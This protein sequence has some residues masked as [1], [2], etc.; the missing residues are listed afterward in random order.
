MVTAGNGR[1]RA[2][3][4]R[5]DIRRFEHEVRVTCLAGAVD[6]EHPRRRVTLG[7]SQQITYTADSL[8]SVQSIDPVAVTAWQRGLL[9]FDNA[10]LTQVVDEINRYRPGRVILRNAALGA[11]RVQAKFSIHRL[12]DAITLMH[13]EYGA[14]VTVLPGRIVLLS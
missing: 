3:Q 12:D 14:H 7:A 2:G 1:M 10:P 13:E 5:F 8:G 11:N 4:A 6:L 9:I